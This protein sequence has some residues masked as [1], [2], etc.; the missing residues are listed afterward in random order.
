MMIYFVSL[1]KPEFTQFAEQISKK[2]TWDQCLAMAWSL[3]ADYTF[4]SGSTA[5]GIKLQLN[6]IITFLKDYCKRNKWEMSDWLKIQMKDFK[7]TL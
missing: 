4:P 7:S 3:Y 1:D 5:A 6:Q 2:T